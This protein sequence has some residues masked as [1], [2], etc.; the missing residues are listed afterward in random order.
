MHPARDDGEKMPCG[1]CERLAAQ[2][3]NSDAALPIHTGVPV[4][5]R[6]RPD[7]RCEHIS[8]GERGSLRAGVRLSRPL[9][10]EPAYIIEDRR[11]N[12]R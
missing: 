10:S 5:C 2:P 1:S 12:S 6:A 7:E 11:P 4:T 8:E 9:P 3:G